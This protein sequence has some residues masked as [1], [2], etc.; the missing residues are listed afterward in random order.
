[1]GKTDDRM[2]WLRQQREA[3]YKAGRLGP[4]VAKRVTKSPVTKSP[5][6]KLDVTKLKADVTKVGRPRKD[7]QAMTGAERM[8]KLRAKRASRSR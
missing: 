1:M 3:D 8:A 5:V 2:A 7:K 6:T 4:R